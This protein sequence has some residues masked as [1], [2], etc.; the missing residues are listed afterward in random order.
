MKVGRLTLRQLEAFFWVARLG[1][2]QAASH[3][4]N[5]SQPAISARI[6][7]LEGEVAVKLFKRHHG[8][9]ELTDKGRELLN[10]G[11]RILT[12]ADELRREAA[13][14]STSP[15]VI[16][17]GIVDSIALTWFP[18]LHSEILEAHP[19]II[20]ELQVDFS[21]NLL[22]AL[23]HGKIDLGFLAGPVQDVD[24]ETQPLGTVDLSWMAGP[25]LSLPGEPATPDC[26]AKL[27]ILCHTR[28]TQQHIIID[29]WFRS[30][31]AAPRSLCFVSSLATVLHLTMAGV[32]L[33]VLPPKTVAP[34]I[35]AGRLKI[36]RTTKPLPRLDFVVAY[37]K[38]CPNLLIKEIARRARS[39]A[40]E[41]PAFVGSGE[42]VAV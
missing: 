9:V 33:S 36:V 1:S 2:F 37:H 34:E 27:P 20:V 41:H 3:Y 19:H 15:A 29:T 5:T 31:H 30:E 28:G 32:G 17:L 23:R 25:G 7:E 13:S 39:I 26:L 14:Q 38:D 35:D 6:K 12:L 8:G 18:V 10:Y 21:I 16:R 11:E 42:I 22:G 24:L 4:L 40:K